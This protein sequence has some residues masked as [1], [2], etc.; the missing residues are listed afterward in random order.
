MAAR[1]PRPARVPALSA[2]ERTDWLWLVDLLSAEHASA[3][4]D[5]PEA[6][7]GRH[8]EFGAVETI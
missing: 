3:G 4:A 5:A 7:E 8:A 6:P 2:A 1:L